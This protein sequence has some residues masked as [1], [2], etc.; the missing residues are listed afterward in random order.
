MHPRHWALLATLQTAKPG[1]KI[2]TDLLFTGPLYWAMAFHANELPDIPT[3]GV[4]KF[5]RT[6]FDEANLK[7]QQKE[8]YRYDLIAKLE[9][10]NPFSSIVPCAN[11]RIG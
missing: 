5:N 7:L 1:I 2:A 11:H 6:E 8:G 10:A 3:I 4:W 9:Y